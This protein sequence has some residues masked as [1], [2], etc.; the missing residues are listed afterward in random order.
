MESGSSEYV[1][2]VLVSTLHVESLGA[3]TLLVS[4]NGWSV[5]SNHLLLAR[6]V[7]SF[8]CSWNTFC[9]SKCLNH[10]LSEDADF[11]LT[12][13]MRMVRWAL[14]PP[15]LLDWLGSINLFP[16]FGKTDLCFMVTSSHLKSDVSIAAM[17]AMWNVGP[18]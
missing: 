14:Q 15:R 5:F 12:S 9:T 1:A 3:A 11:W 16:R 17:D 18:G 7:L 10:W 6:R 2:V 13:M 4:F 8:R